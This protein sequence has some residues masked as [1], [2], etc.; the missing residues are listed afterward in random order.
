[1]KRT[2]G[3]DVAAGKGRAR[4]NVSRLEGGLDRCPVIKTGEPSETVIGTMKEKEEEDEED[5]E[6]EDEE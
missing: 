3:K 5:Q 6:E 4:G 2:I 1:M